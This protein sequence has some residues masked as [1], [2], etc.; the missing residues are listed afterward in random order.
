MLKVGRLGR[1]PISSSIEEME[2]VMVER[3]EVVEGA[4]GAS[5]VGEN[6]DMGFSFLR[7]NVTAEA[8]SLIVMPRLSPHR[9]TPYTLL[10]Y[11]T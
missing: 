2:G 10:Q 5:G 7:T 1:W 8:S 9:S 3:E 11:V 4:D 6:R